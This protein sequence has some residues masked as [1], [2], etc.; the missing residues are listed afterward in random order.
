MPFEVAA[1][2]T[3]IIDELEDLAEMHAQLGG[4]GEIERAHL[5]ADGPVIHPLEA[6]YGNLAG[7]FIPGRRE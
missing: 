5:F 7:R 4:I 6:D 1:H 2:R 3:L